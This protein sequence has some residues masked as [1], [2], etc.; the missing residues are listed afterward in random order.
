MIECVVNISEGQNVALLSKLAHTCEAS[1]LDIHTDPHHNRSVFT[2]G[3]VHLLETLKVLMTEAIS[4]AKLSQH[5]GVH[6]RLGVVDVVPFVPL[7]DSSQ[8]EALEMRDQFVD[9]A[10]GELGVPCFFYGEDRTLP[11]V[12]QHAFV[13]LL[14]DS[15]PVVPDPDVGACV[16]GVRGQL[17][18]YNLILDAPMSR[19]REIA[20]QVRGDKVRTLTFDVGGATQLSTNLID[21]IAFGPLDLY[22]QVTG[23][24]AVKSCELVG[25]V[26][27]E[28]LE[29]IPK[30]YWRIL[31]LNWDKTV[32]YRLNVLGA[33]T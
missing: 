19:G 25:L 3:G 26:T 33:N 21:P 28:V 2:L 31:D 9:F 15:G 11:Y 29:R 4:T 7:G 12:R 17:V 14:P 20:R 18:A 16:V 1:L 27:L 22:R 10:T 32:E 23:E 13:D 6:P 30:Q 5:R 8:S 24:V